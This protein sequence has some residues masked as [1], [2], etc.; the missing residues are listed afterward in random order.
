MLAVQTL[1]LMVLALSLL[2]AQDPREQN[3][4]PCRSGN[5]GFS[6]TVAA[7]HT[8]TH[9]FDGLAFA[10]S[11]I[12]T[13]WVIEVWQGERHSLAY[14]TGPSHGPNPLYIEGWHFR[15]AANTG[16]NTGD[17]NEPQLDRMFVFSPRYPQ[18]EGVAR[19]QRDGEGVLQI[20]KL[21]LANL[22]PGERATIKRMSFRVKLTLGRYA[23][24]PYP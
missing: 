21:E 11:P 12:R 24:A 8:Y 19:E 10:L 2:L 16:P 6:G 18:Y 23:C 22:A 17:V 1:P 4:P 15:N 9:R 14:M 20:T 3:V 5:Y 13:G 7:G